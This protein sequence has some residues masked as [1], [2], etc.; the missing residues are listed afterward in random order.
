MIYFSIPLFKK[1]QGY[2]WFLTMNI[3]WTGIAYLNK[4]R[5]FMNILEYSTL[6]MKTGISRKQGNFGTCP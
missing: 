6:F 1:I 2:S 3:L 5:I 4:T